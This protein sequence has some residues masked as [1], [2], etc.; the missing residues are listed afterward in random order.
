M[1]R[2]VPNEPIPVHTEDDPANV[3][4]IRPRMDVGTLA[5][6]RSAMT[7][8]SMHA[9]VMT[10]AMPTSADL[11]FD[12]GAYNLALLTHNIMRWSGPDFDNVPCNP[13]NIKR[14]DQDDP[15][16]GRVLQEI[17][18]RNLARAQSP[19]LSSGPG[20]KGSTQNG[21]QAK[22]DESLSTTSA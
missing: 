3:I 17:N 11:K 8:I 4:Y 5:L 16:V 21:A 22:R 15:L 10:N 18:N 12:I 14:L 2:F 19:N 1:S 9:N 13:D 6:V 20:T 7:S